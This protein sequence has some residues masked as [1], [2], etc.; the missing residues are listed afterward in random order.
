MDNKEIVNL[1][2]SSHAFRV[3]DPDKPFWYTSGK[4]GPYFINTHF[5]YENEAE[6][7]KLLQ[8]IDRCLDYPLA[9]GRVVGVDAWHQYK[10]HPPYAEVIEHLAVLCQ[11][12]QFDYVSGGARRDFF[13]SFAL[14]ELLGKNHLSILK[15]G[16]VFLSTQHFK[17][18]QEVN[19]DELM[20]AEVLHVADLVT[21]ASSYIRTW[22]PALEE[23]GASISHTL[24]VVDRQ[25]GGRENLATAG[26]DLSTLVTI[27][28]EFFAQARDLGQISQAQEEALDHFFADPDQYMLAFLDKHPKFLKEAKAQ[29]EKTRERVERFEGLGLW[30]PEEP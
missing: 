23:C 9:L 2:F 10:T 14:A 29:D 28:P 8:K 17:Q 11:D 1:L 12:M 7:V 22:L 19:S 4:F 24:A 20:G 6:A 25:Q 26:V 30:H 15:D 5:L 16:A 3:A 21:E 27:G 18:S 13:F